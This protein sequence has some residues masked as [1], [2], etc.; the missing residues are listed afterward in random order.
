MTLIGFITAEE[1]DGRGGRVVM[2]VVVYV[3]AG[4]NWSKQGG[5]IQ[6]DK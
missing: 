3:A 6:E 2:M 5:F 1:E 4:S